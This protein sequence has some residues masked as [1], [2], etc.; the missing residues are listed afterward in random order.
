M[1]ANLPAP[2]PTSTAVSPVIEWR[3]TRGL[4]TA[5]TWLLAADIV[6]TIAVAVATAHH[7]SVVDDYNRYQTSYAATQEASR[8]LGGV[9]ILSGAAFIA[10]TVVFIL[11]TWRGTKNNEALGSL[12]PR[13]TSGWSIGGWFIP[14]GNLWIPGQIMHDLWGGSAPT[15]YDAREGRDARR[16]PLVSWWWG[17]YLSLIHI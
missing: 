6:G 1:T 11:W 17:L 15:G 14:I 7:N 3:S 2:S 10:T 4:R 16:A 12:V 8:L 5:L 13:H 9:A